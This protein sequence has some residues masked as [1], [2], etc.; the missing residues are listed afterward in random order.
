[1]RYLFFIQ[2]EGRGHMTQA[3]SLKNMLEKAGH[4]VAAVIV[5][6]SPRREIPDFF[7]EKIRTRIVTIESPNFIVGKHNKR[8]SIAKTIL[9]NLFYTRRYLKSIQR[10]KQVVKSERPDIII[11]FYSLLGGFFYLFNNPRIPFFCVGHQ[12]LISHSDF[13][14]PKGHRIDRFLLKLNN[15]LTS[16]RADKLIGLSFR[17][18]VD[19]IDK[20]LFVAPPLLRKEVLELTP[21]DQGFLHGYILNDGYA[22]DITAWH[23]KNPKVQAHFFWDKK[24]A[25]E[26]TLIKKNLTFHKI[27]DIKFLDYMSRCKA[28]ASTAG[29]ESI[30]EAMY[31][32]KP[33]MMVP[34]Q[35]HFEQKCNA[36]DAQISGAGIA[37]ETFDLSKLIDYIPLHKNKTKDFQKWVGQADQIFSKLLLPQ[38]KAY[39]PQTKFVYYEYLPNQNGF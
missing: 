27:N 36:L 25:T 13:I 29:F 32:G 31:L 35:G 19:E 16:F 5:G 15:K 30:C 39:T 37:S 10:I 34:T 8:I 2:G 3:I 14:F 12:Y 38:N 18:M 9:H 4:E 7:I 1:M 17:P 20:N 21:K 24:D 6:K 22:E 26:T 11:N 23:S 28:F 33:I